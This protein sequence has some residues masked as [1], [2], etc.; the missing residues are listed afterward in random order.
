MHTPCTQQYNFCS[1]KLSGPYYIC[2]AGGRQE[3]NRG[4]EGV[5][6]LVVADTNGQ[7][8]LEA[9]VCL[10]GHKERGYIQRSR[11]RL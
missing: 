4:V 2:T 5:K 9:L 7:E 10:Q 3:N 8:I 11:R 1:L 6:V